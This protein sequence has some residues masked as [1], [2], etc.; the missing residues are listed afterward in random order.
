MLRSLEEYYVQVFNQ[1]IDISTI[2][3]SSI[4]KDK[5]VD[6]ILNLVGIIIATVVK[7]P[8]EE[9]Q[10]QFVSAIRSLDVEFQANLMTLV[11][12]GMSHMEDLEPSSDAPQSSNHNSNE[13]ALIRAGA[14]VQH[15]QEEQQRLYV[16]VAE[17]EQAK[18]ELTSQNQKLTASLAE[19]QDSRDHVHHKDTKA[20]VIVNLQVSLRLRVER[21]RLT[22]DIRSNWTK[23]AESSI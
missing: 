4:V 14:A 19:Y 7:C 20:D 2:Q 6:E 18:S 15:L 21:G 13:E 11:Q 10:V 3:V 22:Q 5:D 8:D 12:F 1:K 9:L 23:S 16:L 17:L